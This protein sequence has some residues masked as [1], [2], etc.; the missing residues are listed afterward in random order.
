MAIAG[1]LL[2]YV[3]RYENMFDDDV[4]AVLFQHACGSA[5]PAKLMNEPQV[6]DMAARFAASKRQRSSF[7][8]EEQQASMYTRLTAQVK[9]LPPIFLRTGCACQI[10]TL[11]GKQSSG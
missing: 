9:A 3:C 4:A 11:L 6:A 7:V 2:V 8:T 5:S 10:V 1:L